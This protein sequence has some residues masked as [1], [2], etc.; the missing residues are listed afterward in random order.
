MNNE[1]SLPVIEVGLVERLNILAAY[2]HKIPDA[3]ELL[4][5]AAH[6]I[7]ATAKLEAENAE[8][9]KVVV[10]QKS[11]ITT[12]EADLKVAREALSGAVRAAKLAL[13]VIKKQGVMPNGSWER[14]FENDLAPAEAALS[15]IA[16]AEGA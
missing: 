3:V 2:L 9:L 12:L 14:G 13:F 6:R 16:G 11:T 10:V 4:S 7:E 1:Q 15:S 5:D 8:L